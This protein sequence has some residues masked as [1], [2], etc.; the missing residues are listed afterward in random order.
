M[1]ADADATPMP[2][3]MEVWNHRMSR[4]VNASPGPIASP[5]QRKMPP[6]WPQPEASS[7]ATKPVGRKNTRAPMMKSVTEDSP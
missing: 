7:A 1:V 4:H 6:R 3:L 5:T 2:K